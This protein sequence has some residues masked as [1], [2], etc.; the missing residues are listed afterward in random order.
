MAH[1][2]RSIRRLCR[3]CG[4]DCSKIPRVTD[5]YGHYYCQSCARAYIRPH[6]SFENVGPDHQT[7]DHHDLRPEVIEAIRAESGMTEPLPDPLNDHSVDDPATNQPEVTQPEN[8]VPDSPDITPPPVNLATSAYDEHDE[9]SDDDIIPLAP[10]D[11]T[12]DPVLKS[13]PVCFHRYPEDAHTCISCGYV[14]EKGIESSRFVEKPRAAPVVKHVP[15]REPEHKVLACPHCGADMTGA[16]TLNCPSCGRHVSTRDMVIPPIKPTLVEEQVGIAS[17]R[18]EIIV[19][20][21][22]VTLAILAWFVF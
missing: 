13:C 12:S 1:T 22:V 3:I 4:E 16:P 21:V 14:E 19:L 8:S 15:F 6:A 2:V 5:Q 10:E 18:V 11:H 17:R 7:I 9:I 20:L